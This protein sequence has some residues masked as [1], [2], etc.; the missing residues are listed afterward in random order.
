MCCALAVVWPDG[1]EVSVTG[2]LAGTIVFPRGD[3]G[4]GFDPCFLPQ[5]SE[6]TLAEMSMDVRN[7][8]NH[9]Q[10]AFGLLSKQVCWQSV[11][12]KE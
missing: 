9:R 4:F 5:N 2:E 12:L 7:R 6:K 1:T 11:T 10:L 8:T 3:L